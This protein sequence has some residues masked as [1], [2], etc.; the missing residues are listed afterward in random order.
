MTDEEDLVDQI[1]RDPAWLEDLRVSA[2]LESPK[3]HE[4]WNATTKD[5]DIPDGWPDDLEPREVVVKMRERD[6]RRAEEYPDD[7][8]PAPMAAHPPIEPTPP[9]ASALSRYLSTSAAGIHADL[10]KGKR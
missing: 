2:W 4:F 1:L 5:F 9:A 10:V 7:E 6:R 3:C 8:Q